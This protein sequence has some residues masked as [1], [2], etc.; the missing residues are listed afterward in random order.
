M[1]NPVVT[2][3]DWLEPDWVTAA[4]VADKDIIEF[5]LKFEGSISIDVRL[6]RESVSGGGLKTEGS[7]VS[8]DVRFERTSVGEGVE[9]RGGHPSEGFWVGANPAMFS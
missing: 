4:F 7:S 1:T 9:D 8:I 5:E 6:E 3:P 2:S